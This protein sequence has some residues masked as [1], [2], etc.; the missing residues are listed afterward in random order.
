MSTERRP[1]IPPDD[2]SMITLAVCRMKEVLIET[3]K[4]LE[5][6]SHRSDFWAL[7]ILAGCEKRLEEVKAE[8]KIL[9]V[10]ANHHRGYQQLVGFYKMIEKHYKEV[11]R[12]M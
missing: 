8:I 9:A 11:E 6:I 1:Y 2:D 3:D 10:K 4:K 5:K 7:R 12:W